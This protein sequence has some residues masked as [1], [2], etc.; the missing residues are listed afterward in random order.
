MIHKESWGLSEWSI[1]YTQKGFE[2]RRRD[3]AEP[4]P[5]KFSVE[6]YPWPNPDKLDSIT[7]VGH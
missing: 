7:F 3:G 6:N 4:G 1:I 5:R 2:G